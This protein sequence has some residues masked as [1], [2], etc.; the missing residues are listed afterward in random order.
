M[1][2]AIAVCIILICIGGREHH[3][4]YKARHYYDE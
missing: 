1:I 3:H 4:D 2:I